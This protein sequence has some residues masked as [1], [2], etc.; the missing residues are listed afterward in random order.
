M[1]SRTAE[2]GLDQGDTDP[3]ERID[4]LGSRNKLSATRN[5]GDWV[6]L[7]EPRFTLSQAIRCMGGYGALPDLAKSVALKDASS[8]RRATS[9]EHSF[10]QNYYCAC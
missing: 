8:P 4:H 9:C 6:E 2:A 10:K 5:S 3:P 1:P 7:V